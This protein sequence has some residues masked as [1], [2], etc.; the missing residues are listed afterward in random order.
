MLDIPKV[1]R[2][3]AR[4][5]LIPA[6]LL[7]VGGMYWV[8][9]SEILSRL[10]SSKKQTAA[11]LV[12]V[13]RGDVR[14][15]VVENGSLESANNTTVRCEVEALMGLVGGSDQGTGTTAGTTKGATAGGTT[16]GGTTTSAATKSAAGTTK[17]A[18]GGVGTAKA[19]STT[20][21]ATGTAAAGATGTTTASSSAMTG[22]T[23]VGAKPQIRSFSYTVVPHTPLRGY[24]KSSTSTVTKG[25]TGNGMSG[26]GRGGRGGGG[27][28]QE[29][30]G[31]TRI[32]TIVPEGTRVKAGDLV[33]TL[34]ASAFRDEL[35]AQKIRHAQA[36]AWVDQAAEILGVNE[37]TL[38]EYRDG[39][40][41][42]DIQLIRQY[43]QTCQ[44]EKD[45]AERTLIWSRDVASKGFRPTTQVR[46]DELGLQQAEIALR[47]AQ[48]MLTRLELYTGPKIVKSLQAKL[49][50]I[51]QDKLTQEAAFELEDKRLRDL[52]RNIRLCELRAPKDGIVVYA[53]QTNSWGRQTE[54]I[55]QG[56]T[57][58]QGMPIFQLP[59]PKRMR[60]KVR[61]NETKVAL[62]HSG[63][64]AEV[65]IDAFPDQ[66]LRGRVAEVIPIS[67]P[68]NGPFSDVR[69]YNATV[70][71][72]EGFDAL[73]PGLSAEVFFHV[74]S[75]PDV[76]RVPLDSIQWVKERAFVAV[77][78]PNDRQAIRWNWRE[79]KVGLSDTSYAEVLSG[80]E[81]G[82]R[83]IA[84]PDTLPRPDP[85]EL[86][87]DATNLANVPAA[88]QDVN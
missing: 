36:K 64:E 25:A 58:R 44:I 85:A 67:V 59:D 51:R 71:I 30:P 33:C 43:I 63:Q 9:E 23:T 8:Y 70:D 19:G 62:V 34:D 74:E 11:R 69:I 7:A 1:R 53:N 27:M 12:E 76:T 5:L 61:I 56:V 6:A 28:D 73:R 40:L 60:V 65:V 4:L 77:S 35:K 66:P 26:G 54:Q 87:T 57:V 13:G 46:A 29:K 10:L 32:V 39:I 84:D 88:R 79:L 80:V 75:K 72:V 21:S 83:I 52:E 68:A 47:E 86:R 24:T 31:S 16:A 49:Q 42:Q 14:V 3:P 82:E 20:G 55:D 41:P 38:E 22:T 37:I 2:S 78:D 45:R 17:T 18:A 15:V 48:G 81:P 50:A